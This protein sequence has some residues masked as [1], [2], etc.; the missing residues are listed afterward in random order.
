MA[1]QKELL[2][3]L[4]TKYEKFNDNRNTSVYIPDANTHTHTQMYTPQIK[5]FKYVYMRQKYRKKR[6]VLLPQGYIRMVRKKKKKKK[7][8]V[9]KRSAL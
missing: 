3:T 6:R 8:K 5:E 7:T 2:P 9:E 4:I 1:H